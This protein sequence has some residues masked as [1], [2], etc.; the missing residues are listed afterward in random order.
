MRASIK[1]P[2]RKV[3]LR[4]SD[5][6]MAKYNLDWQQ[7]MTAYRETRDSIHGKELRWLISHEQIL[8]KENGQVLDRS[9]IRHPGIVVM[10]PF[11]NEDSVILVRQYRYAVNDELWELPAGTLAGREN[12]HRIVPTESPEVCAARELIEETGFAANRLEKIAECYAIP[13][14]GDELMHFY[15]A[16]DLQTL[17]QSLDVGEIISEVRAFHL[18]ELEAMMERG[19][20]RDAKT[21]IGLFY[22]LRRKR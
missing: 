6:F 1:T 13:G 16:F 8:N 12:N 22:A 10:I 17:E 18:T 7:R 4:K 3:N 19:E 21:L 14:S 15:F 20:I 2:R 11:R 9:F 5:E